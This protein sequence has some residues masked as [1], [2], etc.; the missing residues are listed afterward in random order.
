ML[1]KL[2]TVPIVATLAVLPCRAGADEACAPARVSAAL[3]A[4]RALYRNFLHEPAA[5]RLRA[6]KQRCSPRFSESVRLWVLAD[7]AL[8]ELKLGAKESCRR[9]LD[10]VDLAA[11]ERN[12]ASG[13]ALA[14]TA[15]SCLDKTRDTCDYT[16]EQDA[17]CRLRLALERAARR[18]YPGF[19]A[20]RCSLPG[21][22][23]GIALP[24]A[25]G[26]AASR[27]LLIVKPATSSS[28]SASCPE[29]V[30][31]GAAG[32][33]ERLRLKGETWGNDTCDC[34][35][36][37]QVAARLEKGEVEVLLSRPFGRDCFGGTAAHDFY[38]IFRLVGREL[39][40]VRDLSIGLH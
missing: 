24:A 26:A 7:L 20:A 37:D 25:A 32:E 11:V 15:A 4:A 8:I 27:C 21:A 22:A 18:R 2:L 30:L 40:L 1:P 14:H 3:S 19:K 13:K 10:E 6:L 33:R 36:L 28:G 34:C 17:H 35:N 16:L 9:L 38:T 23:S 31:V 39:V 29:L 12:P 5:V